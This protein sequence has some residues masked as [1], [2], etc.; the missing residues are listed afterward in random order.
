MMQTIVP[1]LDPCDPCN[2]ITIEQM[3]VMVIYLLQKYLRAAVELEECK[4]NIRIQIAKIAVDAY[5]ALDTFW[6]S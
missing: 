4:V 3:N 6:K 2:P 5:R 1:D